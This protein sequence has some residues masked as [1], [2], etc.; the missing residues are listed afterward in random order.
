[1]ILKPFSMI[2]LI[3]Y[4]LFC[5]LTR[6]YT[7]KIIDLYISAYA[8]FNILDLSLCWLPGEEAA[9]TGAIWELWDTGCSSGRDRRRKI[10]EY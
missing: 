4:G 10:W 3:K 8:L 7:H 6:T 1:M 9:L 5:T 2:Y